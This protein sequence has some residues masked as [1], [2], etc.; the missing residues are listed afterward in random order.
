MRAV[1]TLFDLQAG[2]SEIFLQSPAFPGG[3]LS[4]LVEMKVSDDRATSGV[5]HEADHGARSVAADPPLE[6]QPELVPEQPHWGS[7]N[8]PPD[9]TP[10][11]SL[12]HI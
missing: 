4:R 8:T 3:E 12:I 2:A 1:V 9:E 5:S 10:V 6:S 7:Y 11:L